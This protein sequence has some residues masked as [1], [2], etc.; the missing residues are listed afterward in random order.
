MAGTLVRRD[1]AQ[2]YDH[3]GDHDA[4][5][6]PVRECSPSFG[7]VAACVGPRR[8]AAAHEA[9]RASIQPTSSPT[10]Q[11][12]SVRIVRS[13]RTIPRNRGTG[14]RSSV[15]RSSRTFSRRAAIRNGR[16][17]HAIPADT[18]YEMAY[19][20]VSAT[21]PSTGWKA[22]PPSEFTIESK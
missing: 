4:A 20:S 15:I 19:P 3:A 6:D 21:R 5:A 9:V 18:T 11:P 22:T 7:N 2:Q 8:E 17:M 16:L 12:H 10:A 1:H 14:Q 13:Y